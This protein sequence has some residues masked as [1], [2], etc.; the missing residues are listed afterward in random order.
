MFFGLHRLQIQVWSR[1]ACEFAELAHSRPGR[2]RS[3]VILRS[4]LLV[5]RLQLTFRR[6]DRCFQQSRVIPE[7][8]LHAANNRF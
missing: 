8:S 5:Q 2:W 7:C 4:M 1:S 6:L 3:F